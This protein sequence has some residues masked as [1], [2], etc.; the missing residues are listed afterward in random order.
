MIGC[1][2]TAMV[3]ASGVLAVWA[4]PT[5]MTAAA[6]SCRR[7]QRAGERMLAPENKFRDAVALLFARPD[8]LMLELGAGGELL[9]GACAW[10][11]RRCCCCCR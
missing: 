8:E 3:R 7:L 5:A 10:W 1:K 9:V 4:C 2:L 6:L 11:W